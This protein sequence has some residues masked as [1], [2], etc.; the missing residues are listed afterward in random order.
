M[1]DVSK[2]EIPPESSPPHYP[3]HTRTIAK[4]CSVVAFMQSP[5]GSDVPERTN[6]ES[7]EVVDMYM[8]SEYRE[9]MLDNDP[10]IVLTAI[11]E[12]DVPFDSDELY[13]TIVDAKGEP[14]YAN[15]RWRT[16]PGHNNPEMSIPD[17]L[18]ILASAV[19]EELKRSA[20]LSPSVGASPSNI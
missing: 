17:Y 10:E 20:Y 9:D 2:Q 3:A 12:E 13:A 11:P 15:E 19:D 1:L 14:L 7:H 18:E 4:S 8:K 6:S 5:T 16:F